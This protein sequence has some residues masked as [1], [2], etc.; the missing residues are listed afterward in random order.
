[1][2]H[3]QPVQ[4]FFGPSTITLIVTDALSSTEFSLPVTV[5]ATNDPPIATLLPFGNPRM[6]P[7]TGL[8]VQLLNAITIT[9]GLDADV[10]LAA[11]Q[12]SNTHRLGWT[13][14][15]SGVNDVDLLSLCGDATYRIAGNTITS[16]TNTVLAT[17]SRPDGDTRTIDVTAAAAAT[18]IQLQE[19]ARLLRFSHLQS[20][21][22]DLTRTVTIVVHEPE[23]DGTPAVAPAVTMTV[24]VLAQNLPP[25]VTAVP[26]ELKPDNAAALHL[27]ISDD[28]D[29]ADIR[30]RLVAPPP[31]AGRVE[32]GEC[33]ASEL[34][35]GLMRYTHVD[36]DL[37]GD[38]VTLAIDDG[39]QQ[40]VTVTVPV[41][42]RIPV[43]RMSVISD[44]C[45][46]AVRGV[47]MDWPMRFTCVPATVGISAL[48][49]TLPALP[50]GGVTATTNGL[51]FHWAEIPANTTWLPLRVDAATTNVTIAETQR[52]TSQRMMIRVLPTPPVA[53]RR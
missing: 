41:T 8:P 31:L 47:T 23:S 40:V 21:A 48:A 3:L 33:S 27:D 35:A 6:D 49:S 29:L 24:T 43:E 18:Q 9:P 46:V 37:A 11:I 25:V 28:D 13:A 12:G 26:V 42:V 52:S 4:D 36:P 10:T 15:V 32:P 17:W 20:T 50:A 14:S 2:V 39:R 30:V 38:S 51:V 53:D 22:R 45:L 34:A 5:N 44:P 19:M 16:A 7:G 1:M